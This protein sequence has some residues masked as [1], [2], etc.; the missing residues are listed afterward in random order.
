MNAQKREQKATP[1]EHGVRWATSKGG[2]LQIAVGPDKEFLGQREVK[3]WALYTGSHDVAEGRTFKG[4]HRE[5]E[6]RDYAN[7]LWR[8]R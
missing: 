8:T 7:R 5:Q 4:P 2:N 6:A 3:V 1:N